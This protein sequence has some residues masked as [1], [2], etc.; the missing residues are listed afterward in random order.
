[1]AQQQQCFCPPWLQPQTVYPVSYIPCIFLC[2]LTCFST[3]RCGYW[4]VVIICFYNL[5][6]SWS[7]RWHTRKILIYY[8][9]DTV[10]QPGSCR[11]IWYGVMGWWYSLVLGCG[12]TW[13][14]YAEIQCSQT[15]SMRQFMASFVNKISTPGVI[16]DYRI[17]SRLLWSATWPYPGSKAV[18]WLVLYLL[19]VSPCLP[20]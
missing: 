11:R 4:I 12:D 8:H 17:E 6:R 18:T 9:W 2:Y 15:F 10:Y 3:S 5:C 1:M 13:C 16:I 20:K 7:Q 19:T 14:I